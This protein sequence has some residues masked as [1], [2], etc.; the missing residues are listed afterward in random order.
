MKT[1]NFYEKYIDDSLSLN[2]QLAAAQAVMANERTLLSFL[3]TALAILVAALSLIKF[4]ELDWMVFAGWTL[5]NISLITV[6]IG[7]YRY[8][9][10][11]NMIRNIE[12][13]S[14][15]LILQNKFNTDSDS[16]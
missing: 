5:F 7:L 4:F 9:R 16:D 2:D 1:K 3:R 14:H 6:A 10:M 8:H 11:K 15:K 13:H 12:E